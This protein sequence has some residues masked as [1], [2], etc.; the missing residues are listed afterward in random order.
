MG[1]SQ[2]AACRLLGYFNESA[3]GR[4]KYGLFEPSW[5]K[6]LIAILEEEC[7]SAVERRSI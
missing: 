4:I 6:I 7:G 3:I 2:R 1:I 5:E